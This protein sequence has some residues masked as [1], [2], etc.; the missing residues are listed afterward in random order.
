MVNH[1]VNFT[2]IFRYPSI[3]GI[4]AG[5]L[6]FAIYLSLMFGLSFICKLNAKKETKEFILINVISFI[7]GLL[8]FLSVGVVFFI[9][10]PNCA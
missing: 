7:S 10:T 6:L 3:K 1:K 4:M 9:E 5:S 8:L 2:P